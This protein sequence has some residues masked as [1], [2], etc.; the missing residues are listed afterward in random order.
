MELL[1]RGSWTPPTQDLMFFSTGLTDEELT[2]FVDLCCHYNGD[3]VLKNTRHYDD[4]L[5]VPSW[6]V[7]RDEYH[8]LA[9]MGLIDIV[10]YGYPVTI[11]ITMHGKEIFADLKKYDPVLLISAC[12]RLEAWGT[13]A[14]FVW[15]LLSAPQLPEFLTHDNKEIRD[16]AAKRLDILT[17]CRRDV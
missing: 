11:R 2:C 15:A 13:A 3:P 17:T 14:Y 16:L 9:V 4:D 12:M 8:G 1:S 6:D 10:K 7:I 5:I